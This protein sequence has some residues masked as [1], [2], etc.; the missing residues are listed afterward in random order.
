M[1]ILKSI[2]NSNTSI[3]IHFYAY[4]SIIYLFRDM[5]ISTARLEHRVISLLEGATQ[6]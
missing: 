2:I 6:D 5:G 1:Y 4:L 3:S